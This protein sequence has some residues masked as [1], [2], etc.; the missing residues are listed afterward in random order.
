L[1]GITGLGIYFLDRIRETGD[2]KYLEKI[3]DRLSM[4]RTESGGCKIWI[5]ARLWEIQR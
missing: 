3:V 2:P 5:T 1:H 4:M